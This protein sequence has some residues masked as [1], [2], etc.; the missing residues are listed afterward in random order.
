MSDLKP[1][2]RIRLLEMPDDPCPVPVGTEGTVTD[3]RFPTAGDAQHYGVRWDGGRSL[4]LIVGVDRWELVQRATVP[5]DGQCQECGRD[6]R[7]EEPQTRGL[8][9]ADDCPS[10]FEAVG[11][12]FADG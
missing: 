3:Y 9:D 12:E 4:N 11:K 7:G 8:C 6:H 5:A 1:G 10:R 2:D